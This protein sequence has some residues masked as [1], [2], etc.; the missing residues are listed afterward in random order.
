MIETEYTI[1]EVK[2]MTKV[3]RYKRRWKEQRNYSEYLK[4]KLAKKAMQVQE[5]KAEAAKRHDTALQLSANCG[6][7]GYEIDSLKTR[8]TELGVMIERL[9]DVGDALAENANDWVAGAL[10][11]PVI[12]NWHALVTEWKEIQ[13]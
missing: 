4:C 10:H 13:K 6:A 2:L 3:E 1:D 7:A 9:V 12:D 8:I 11:L 5:L